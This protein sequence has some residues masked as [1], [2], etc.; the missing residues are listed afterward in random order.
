MAEAS[1]PDRPNIH[2]PMA[3][4]YLHS[5]RIKPTET[6]EGASRRGAMIGDRFT[7]GASFSC[8][9]SEVATSLRDHLNCGI[10]GTLMRGGGGGATLAALPTP[11]GSTDIFSNAP[12]V[13]AF[14]R[15]PPTSPVPPTPPECPIPAAPTPRAIEAAGVARTMNNAI[16]TFTEVLDMG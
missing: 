9:V 13:A 3:A 4:K 2:R 7:P 11:L 1:V 12:R 16:A 15:A 14:G 8:W 5:A 10:A 6:R